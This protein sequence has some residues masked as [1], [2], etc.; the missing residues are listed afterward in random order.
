MDVIHTVFSLGVPIATIAIV[1]TGI[2]GQLGSRLRWME[3]S[4]L[5]FYLARLS[6][7]L[8]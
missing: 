7:A 6:L 2:T 3:S 5:F 8:A 4:F 1:P